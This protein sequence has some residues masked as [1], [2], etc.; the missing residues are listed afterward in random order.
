MK[1]IV[2]E[3][4]RRNVFKVA[5][6]YLITAWIIIQI[7]SVISPYLHLP[8]VF[9]TAI[10][11]ILMI[12]F[13]VVCIFAW[14][15]E[16]TPEG[17][18]PTK[19][20]DKDESISHHTGKKL[21]MTLAVLLVAVVG[22][23]IYDKT[24]ADEPVQAQ[25]QEQHQ[26]NSIDPNS[27]ITNTQVNSQSNAQPNVQTN[28]QTNSQTN[29]KPAL[30]IAVLP[31]VNMSSDQENEFFSDGLTEEILNKLAR[32][33]K[34]QVT[35][36][37]SSFFY[38]GTNEDLRDIGNKLGVS[39]ILEGSVR[40]SNDI[41]RITAQLIRVTDGFH[42][43]SDTYDKNTKDTFAV[44]DE[45]AT[46]VT[47]ALDI[48]LDEK[49][50][51]AMQNAGLGDVEAFIAYQKGIKQYN[52]AHGSS[53][54]LQDLL[55]ANDYFNE[56]IKHAPDFSEAY[57]YKSDYYTHTALGDDPEKSS[58]ER[59]QALSTAI[60]LFQMAVDRET[61][62]ELQG[63]LQISKILLSNNWSELKQHIANIAEVTQ[64]PRLSWLEMVR[65]F[66]YEELLYKINKMSLRCDPLNDGFKINM[67]AALVD[68]KR[69]DEALRLIEKRELTHLTPE[70]LFVK[71]DVYLLQKNFAAAKSSI[72]KI[73]DPKFR[74]FAILR[75]SAA[76][77]DKDEVIRSMDKIA[78]FS[79]TTEEPL[80]RKLLS[81]AMLGDRDSANQLAAQLEEL[82]FSTYNLLQVVENCRCGAPFDLEFTPIL[83]KRLQEANLQWPPTKHFDLPLKDW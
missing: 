16:L 52:K 23:V 31:F 11:V 38:K 76:Q 18:K 27:Q 55:T 4:R 73:N 83:K 79:N 17:I 21:S 37:T 43:W 81:S 72:E 8:T 56:A 10:T 49:S 15:F 22:F 39:Y 41:A 35:A 3:L 28:A 12:G 47:K 9:G 80:R 19:E 13:P 78:D 68:T 63:Y 67:I 65:S 50:R 51:M 2:G 74:N 53:T 59:E 36:R 61:N 48:I 75:Y 66:G 20:V 64:C 60:A 24:I 45:I 5:S 14:A 82:P 29:Q 58:Q 69:Y 1:S 30:S 54:M 71:S 6:V 7:V 32:V 70:L 42:L 33:P 46:N 25:I 77:G 44:Q 26:N 34:L 40:K 57:S 62:I